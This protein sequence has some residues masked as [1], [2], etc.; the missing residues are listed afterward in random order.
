MLTLPWISNSMRIHGIMLSYKALTFT[1]NINIVSI[2]KTPT[3]SPSGSS[4]PRHG[5]GISNDQLSPEIQ[6][7][8]LHNVTPTQHNKR[9]GKIEYYF[10]CRTI[11]PNCFKLSYEKIISHVGYS[12]CKR[13]DGKLELALVQINSAAIVLSQTVISTD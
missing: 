12:W 6:P 11:N 5:Q 9:K 13:A 1:F 10:F 2:I 3:D 7:L 4:Q 8:H